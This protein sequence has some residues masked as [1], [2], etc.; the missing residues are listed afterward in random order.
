MFVRKQVTGGGNPQFRPYHYFLGDA[1][2]H[3]E[4]VV[5]GFLEYCQSVVK[6]RHLRSFASASPP[7]RDYIKTFGLRISPLPAENF[8]IPERCALGTSMVECWPIVRQ[9]EPDAWVLLVSQEWCVRKK[10]PSASS[11]Y[12]TTG[13][14]FV[15]YAFVRIRRQIRVSEQRL[16]VPEYVEVVGGAEEFLGE[17]APYLT[18]SVIDK[19]MD[20][21]E[22]RMNT[23]PWRRLKRGMRYVSTLAKDEA[24]SIL[25]DFLEDATFCERKREAGNASWPR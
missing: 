19:A 11:M 24:W 22:K 13:V 12:V 10:D 2:L 15:R 16:V 3:P 25:K 17:T 8:A 21:T 14:P 5:T 9:L 23:Q 4:R 6:D 20:D 1:L 7:F 18:K